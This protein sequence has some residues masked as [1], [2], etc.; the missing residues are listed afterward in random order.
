MVFKTRIKRSELIFNIIILALFAVVASTQLLSA[1][2]ASCVAWLPSYWG[3]EVLAS[4]PPFPPGFIITV[5]FP[6]MTEFSVLFQIMNVF[7]WILAFAWG[8]LLYAYFT[9]WPWKRIFIMG[10]IVAALGFITGIIPAI[11]A[12]TNGFT[13]LEWEAGTPFVPV[14]DWVTFTFE[15]GSPHWGRTMAN[16]LMMIVFLV[17]NFVPRLKVATKNFVEVRNVAGQYTKQLIIMALF[18]F[19][20]GAASFLG[21]SFMADAHVVG[22]INVWET[23]E[24]QFL[25][26]VVTS[27]IGASMLSTAL[28]YH[29]IRPSPAL[30][31]AK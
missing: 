20:L 27:L 7:T 29:L 2:G 12:D 1:Y 19:W 26:G 31:T 22:G 9:K 16:F 30:I 23:I 25:G 28:I 6:Y 14:Q 4:G 3:Q 11:I 15:I 8:F 17:M 21:T 13:F 10:M 24:L 5:M 18:F